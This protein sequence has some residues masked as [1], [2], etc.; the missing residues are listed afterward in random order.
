MALVYNYSD[1]VVVVVF[2]T[3]MQTDHSFY[4]HLV[5]NDIYSMKDILSRAQKYI[6]LEEA[7]AGSR[8]QPPK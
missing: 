7:I 4:Q 2:T 3:R 6:Q 8:S 1:H 5:K